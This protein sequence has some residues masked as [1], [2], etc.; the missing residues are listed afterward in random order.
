MALQAKPYRQKIDYKYDIELTDV[1]CDMEETF[2]YQCEEE[3]LVNPVWSDWETN[4]DGITESR[5]A[6]AT[7]D[8]TDAEIICST[9]VENR[10]I[11]TTPTTPTTPAVSGISTEVVP[12]VLGATA[13]PLADTA[14]PSNLLAYV[15]QGILVLSLLG[16]TG[17]FAKRNLLTLVK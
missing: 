10:N 2:Y 1:I 9:T 4:A 17:I 6:P 16:V 11:P 5:T 3:V 12:A 13:V 8:S 7:V 14:A 15:L